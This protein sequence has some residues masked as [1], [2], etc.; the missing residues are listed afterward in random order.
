MATSA[1]VAGVLNL[2]LEVTSHYSHCILFVRS[3][4][5]GP[6]YIKGEEIAQ[7]H[8]YRDMEVIGAVV[9]TFLTTLRTKLLH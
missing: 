3:E 4:L 1:E 8:K 9:E 6:V 7:R 2:I 5:P